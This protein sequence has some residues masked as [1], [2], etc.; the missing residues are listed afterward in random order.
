[1]ARPMVTTTTADQAQLRQK[2][3]TDQIAQLRQTIH[4]MDEG[5][6]GESKMDE[7]YTKANKQLL[8]LNKALNAVPQT[9]RPFFVV[10]DW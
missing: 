10:V 3:L 2:E 9:G 5:W 7:P 1:M 4:E 6:F 8:K